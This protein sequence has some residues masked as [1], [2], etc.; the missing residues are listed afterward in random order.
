MRIIAL[1]IIAGIAAFMGWKILTPD[2]P[3]AIVATEA[4]C[5]N[6]AG[7][8]R[9]FCSRAFAQTEEAI[10]RAGNVFKSQQDC[11][12]KFLNCTAF[13]GV[14]G[15]TPQ[16]QGFCIARGADGAMSRMTPV[17]DRPRP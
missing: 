16:P 15:W 2:C 9:A 12:V 6:V 11:Q 17:Y 4:E 14:H 5:V 8:D 10:L 3:G 7:F 1:A 13:P